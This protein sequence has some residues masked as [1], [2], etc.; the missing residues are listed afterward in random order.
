MPAI[1]RNLFSF[2]FV[3]L[4]SFSIAMLAGCGKQTVPPAEGGGGR[5]TSPSYGG[6]SSGGTPATAPRGSKPY[7]VMGKTY[8]PLLSADN[9][10]E[11]GVASWY[12]KDFHGKQA[13]NGERYDMYDMTAAHKLL[14]FGTMVRVTN[15]NNGKSIVV[16]IN[17][18]G[19][20]VDSRI[21]DLSH[22]GAQKIDMLGAGT[23]PV[24]IET[25]GQVKGLHDGKLEGQ[26]YIQVG[27][28]QLEANAT[29]L[30]QELRQRG[31]SARAVFASAINFWRVQIGPYTDLAKA[32][33]A[34]EGLK[35][36]YQNN[37]IVAD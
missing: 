4:L 29:N 1:Y 21:I 12:G 24:M 28:F 23:A 13:A 11:E 16:R 5:Q 22:T 3:A 34:S 2:V 18:R 14:P 10:R 26:F 30:V 36:E 25:I 33:S 6:G 27:A 7:T 17:D 20:F 15:K 37:F 31:Y 9:Y 35:G 8:Y 32:E 19:P